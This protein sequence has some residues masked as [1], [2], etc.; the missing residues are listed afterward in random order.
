MASGIILNPESHRAYQLLLQLHEH[1]SELVQLLLALSGKMNTKNDEVCN[2]CE[3]ISA[4]HKWYVEIIDCGKQKRLRGTPHA[5]AAV[6]FG[7]TVN[8]KTG[9]IIWNKDGG[10][11]WI[12]G[13][14]WQ[15]FV[16][17]HYGAEFAD[18][19]PAGKADNK[20]IHVYKTIWP[21]IS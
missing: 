3:W 20:H 17:Q 1:D 2:I 6:L 10:N 18:N 12:R 9:N 4:E 13:R 7:M 5:P 16:N 19:G 21:R 14:R 11:C 15:N 8:V